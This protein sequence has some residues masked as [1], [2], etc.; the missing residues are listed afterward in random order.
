MIGQHQFFSSTSPMLE[1]H[2]QR[3]QVAVIDIGSNA[4]R[5][6]VFHHQRRMGLPLIYERLACGLGRNLATTGKLHPDGVHEALG[7]LKRFSLLLKDFHHVEVVGTAALREASDGQDFI[8]KVKADTG[9]VIT[10]IS[11]EEESRLGALGVAMSLPPAANNEPAFGLMG[12]MGG[13]SLELASANAEHTI[14]LPLGALRLLPLSITEATRTVTAALHHLSPDLVEDANNRIFACVGG[15]W[16][17]LAR[18]HI[19]EQQYPLPVVDQYTMNIDDALDFTAKLARSTPNACAQIGNIS[20]KR[21]EVIPMA[22]MVLHELLDYLQPSS[23]IFSAAGLREGVLFDQLPHEERQHDPLLLTASECWKNYPPVGD[24]PALQQFVNT[25]MQL[26]EGEFS[27]RLCNASCGFATMARGTHPDHR[28]KDLFNRVLYGNYLGASHSD[29]VWIA[30]AL[31]H[32]YEDVPSD[33]LKKFIPLMSSIQYQQ[34]RLCGLSLQL[35]D[36]IDEFF[37]SNLRYISMSRQGNGFSLKT[38]AEGD[39]LINE[40]VTKKLE[41]WE[42]ILG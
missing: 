32:Y 18:I 19:A 28:G 39:G 23:L 30:I 35:A 6:V 4:L 37:S 3:Q 14:T 25:M 12:D 22:A 26:G 38:S 1:H 17:A 15:A 27:Q 13:G 16:R 41:Q 11:G 31:A 21:A 42:K 33:L 8:D 36:A 9:L 20:K 7:C 10:V 29:R 40:A 24:L 34:A 5:L 2:P